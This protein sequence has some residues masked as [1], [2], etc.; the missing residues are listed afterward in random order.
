MRVRVFAL[1]M[2]LVLP[3]LLQA[4]LFSQQ[5]AV[6]TPFGSIND[7]YYESYGVSW[8]VGWRGGFARFGMPGQSIPPFGKFD[9]SAGIQT[10]W[11]FGNGNIHGSIG[12]SAA[13]GSNR[14]FTSQ[15]PFVTVLN[16]YPGAFYDFSQSPFVT[17]YVPVVGDCPAFGPT[18][19]GVVPQDNTG[20]PNSLD[21]VQVM[22]HLLAERNQG[23][24]AE[25]NDV[26]PGRAMLPRRT[27]AA[28][29]ESKPVAR[30]EEHSA[31]ALPAPSVAEAKR[32]RELEEKSADGDVAVLFEKAKAAEEN[33]QPQVAKIYYQMV[34]RRAQG[35]L[36]Q[37]AERRLKELPAQRR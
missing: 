1:T 22:R 21:R 15:T 25:A 33:H 37:T 3:L 10:G 35:D 14:S 29:A 26:D 2:P 13:Q 30:P 34:V 19:P 24:P 27:V 17:G 8:N 11:R 18:M 36:K 23:T 31:A 32:L 7:G 12:F 16:G 4:S 20:D 5:L 9:P 28:A 6:G